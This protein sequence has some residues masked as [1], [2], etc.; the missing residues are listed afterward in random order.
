MAKLKAW[1]GTLLKRH[2]LAPR[3]QEEREEES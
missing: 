2:G 1:T 3:G